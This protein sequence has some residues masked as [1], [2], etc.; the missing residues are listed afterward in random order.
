MFQPLNYYNNVVIE[1]Y[2]NLMYQKYFPLAEL[3]L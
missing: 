3:S 1:H 2:Q